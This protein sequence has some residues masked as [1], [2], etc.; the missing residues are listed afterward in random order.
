[1]ATAVKCDDDITS[2]PAGLASFCQRLRD[3]SDRSAGFVVRHV[4]SSGSM[5]VAGCRVEDL[6]AYY[7]APSAL[8]LAGRK[9]LADKVLSHALESFA[10]ECEGD[11]ATGKGVGK[12]ANDA[13][14][15]YDPYINGWLALCALRLERHEAAASISRWLDKFEH[16]SLGGYMLQ[17]YSAAGENQVDLL[18]TSHIGM[19]HLESGDLARARRC[20]DSIMRQLEAHYSR[21]G[22]Q[23]QLGPRAFLRFSDRSMAVVDQYPEDQKP[24]HVV[25]ATEPHQ[26]YFMVGYPI[27]YL[28][29]LVEATQ[30]QLYI[31]GAV[32]L[33][34]FC[35]SCHESM[36]SF[37]FAHKVAWAAACLARLTGDKW[38]Y[39]MSIRVASSLL[40]SQ[41][42]E[43]G[44]FLPGDPIHDRIDQT[45]ELSMWLRDVAR[46]LSLFLDEQQPST[47]LTPTA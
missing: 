23:R 5:E 14:R 30:E 21:S 18:L 20:G 34:E 1:M 29:K 25:D 12:T 4:S 22:E 47:A 9:D 35:A 40:D 16:P 17:P 33:A 36:Y 45:A 41:D 43:T 11:F 15:L 10:T 46:M 27:A 37:H 2:D 13:L 6:A 24:F 44:G 32:C 7:K 31:Q 8:L 39:G 26:L 28:C 42:P 3:A 38:L 19:A